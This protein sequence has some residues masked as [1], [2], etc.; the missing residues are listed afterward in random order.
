MHRWVAWGIIATGV[1]TFVSLFFISAPYGRHE[2]SGWGPTMPTRWAWVIMESPAVLAFAAIYLLGQ[3]RF[4]VAPLVLLAMW[5]LHYVNRTFAF[6]FEL[7]VDGKTTPIAVAAMAIVFNFLNAYVNARQISHLGSYATGWLY[8]PRF[9]VGLALF[10]GGRHINIEAD[11]RL[12]ALREEGAG[13]EIPRG[14]LYRYIS[15]PNYFGEIV[16]WIGW[17]VAIWSLAGASFAVFT[18]A[19]LA[20]RAISHH[21]WYHEKFPDYP[22][23]RKALVP[24]VV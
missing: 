15:C 19:N 23:E 20:P 1:L 16:E 17:A 21:R 11:R 5:Q 9:I 6:P 3:H 7:K 12:V 13:Y 22:P 2:R 10:L 14:W 24:F 18:I 8:D 4:A